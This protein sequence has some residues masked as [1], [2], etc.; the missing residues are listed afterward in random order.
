MNKI[1]AGNNPPGSD[2]G[3][4]SLAK[5]PELCEPFVIAGK[6][7]QVFRAIELKA[8]YEAGK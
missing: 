1:Y 7:K 5:Q 3:E 6:A 2:H 4:G 8:Q